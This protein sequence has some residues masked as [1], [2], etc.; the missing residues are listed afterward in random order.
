MVTMKRWHWIEFGQG[1]MPHR[2]R[3]DE[4]TSLMG[5]LPSWLRPPPSPAAAPQTG[6]PERRTRPRVAALD[7]PATSTLSRAASLGAEHTTGRCELHAPGAPSKCGRKGGLY[8]QGAPSPPTGYVQGP[9]QRPNTT[10][11][12]VSPPEPRFTGWWAETW[13]TKRRHIL[14]GQAGCHVTHTAL[15]WRRGT[16]SKEWGRQVTANS[17][18]HFK[19][20][21]C[22]VVPAG[23]TLPEHGRWFCGHVLCF[24]HK[25]AFAVEVPAVVSVRHFS[26][27]WFSDIDQHSAWPPRMRLSSQCLSQAHPVLFPSH[28]PLSPTNA[29]LHIAGF[30]RLF[31]VILQRAGQPW[32]AQSSIPGPGIFSHAAFTSSPGHSPGW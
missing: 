11:V 18:D 24:Y 3:T 12:V 10:L 29:D 2:G 14:Q 23:N 13:K 20:Q 25:A 17:G 16:G 32:L 4:L 1:A 7:P 26:G 9:C 8:R 27:L 19:F 28:G 5:Q 21:R 30:P 31:Q 6:R 22:C 15:C